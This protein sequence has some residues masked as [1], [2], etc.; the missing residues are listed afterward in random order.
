MDMRKGEIDFVVDN[1]FVVGDESELFFSGDPVEHIRSDA[2]LPQVL[3]LAGIFD[4]RSQAKK[5]MKPFQE[6][7]GTNDR[8]LPDGF[9]QF[10][11]GKR[12]HLITVLKPTEANLQ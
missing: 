3:F 1:E 8:H 11:A 12:N 5:N 4:S 10:R 7:I 2:D 9:I 6:K